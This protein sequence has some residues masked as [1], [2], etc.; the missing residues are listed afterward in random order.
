[1]S[2]QM[3]RTALAVMSWFSGNRS[4]GQSLTDEFDLRVAVVI[5]ARHCSKKRNPDTSLQGIRIPTTEEIS[6]CNASIS[7]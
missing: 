2:S 6:S 3:Q 5:K 1:M 7:F 4:I